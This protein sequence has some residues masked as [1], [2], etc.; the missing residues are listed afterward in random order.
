MR[1]DELKRLRGMLP[2]LTAA[3][4]LELLKQLEGARSLDEATDIIEKRRAERPACPACGAERVVRN[5]LAN[6]LQRYK[7]H[8]CSITFNALTGTS[9]ARLRY[10]EKWLGQTQVLSDGLS[11]RK[12][13]ARLGVHRT[14]AFR[15]RHRWLDRPREVKA[16]HMTGVVEADETYHLR[17]YKGQRA[18]LKAQSVRLPRRRGGVAAKRGL[19]AE[20]TPILTLVSR[21]GE[22]SDEVLNFNSKAAVIRVLPPALAD[23][24]VLCTDGSYM[25]AT[26]AKDLGIEHQA[27]NTSAG[28]HTRGPWHIQ[29]V[30][31]YHSRWKGWLRRFN[32]ISS[33]YLPNYLGW[34][35][36]LD[37]N[38]RTKAH[39]ASLLALAIGM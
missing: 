10:R 37:R 16:R 27:V 6:G 20:H 29:N 5:G 8:R 38:S 31:S 11:V 7:C 12:A 4:R 34:F 26:A 19:S 18:L 28:S 36:A 9:L 35:R 1:T 2:R 15:W 33:R 21:H 3:Q 32:G 30:N 25:L 14:T 39:P 17:S 23:D 13:A 24:A 22:T